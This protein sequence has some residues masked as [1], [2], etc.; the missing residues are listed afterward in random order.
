MHHEHAP[1]RRS[2]SRSATGTDPRAE[3]RR[4]FDDF[5]GRSVGEWAAWTP[6]A[7]LY[8]TEETY[9]L[10]MEAPGF[11]RD[12]LEI[13]LEQGVLTISG[14]RASERQERQA[15]YHLRERSQGR[16]S[17]SFRVPRSIEADDVRAQFE[18]GVLRVE[19]PKVE[20]AKPRRIEV[21]GG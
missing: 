3:M 14:Q 10:E 18:Q 17:R 4:L 6:A 8:E 15:T 9:V 16:F 5:F 21:H 13:T 11:D 19:L 2:E 20:H 1:A 7:D 12:D